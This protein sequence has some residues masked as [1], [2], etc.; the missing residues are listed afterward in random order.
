[1]ATLKERFL[2]LVGMSAAAAPAATPAP[3]KGA[4]AAGAGGGQLPPPITP[5]V[6]KG[7]Q[8]LPSFL[9]TATPQ[10]ILPQSDLALATTDILSLRTGTT[11][12]DMQALVAAS[13]DL[14]AAVFAYLRTAL[15][16]YVAVAKNRDGTFNVPATQLLQQ[17]IT[18]MDVLPDYKIGF[19]GVSSMNSLSESLAKEILTYGACGLELVLDKAR[20]PQQL[21]PVSVTTVKFG[22]DGTRRLPQQRLGGVVVDLDI[23]SFFYTSLD[24]DLLNPYAASPLQ[25]ALQPVIFAAD[26][27]N[28]LRRVV[29]KAVHPRLEVVIDSDKVSKL[30][31][32]DTWLDD[33]KRRV[34]MNAFVADVQ[35]KINGL[36]P[37]DALVY[38]DS[39]DIG[40]ITAGNVSVSDEWKVLQTIADAK[41]ATGAKTMPSILGH[42]SGSQN[43]ASVETMLFMKSATGA[44][45][46]KLNEIYS[47]AFT[48]AL[49]LFG[50]DVVCEWK[51]DSVDLRPDTELEAFK[52]MKQSRILEQLSYGFIT[53]EEAS[54]ALIG[55]LPGPSLKPLSGTLFFNPAPNASAEG[56]AG[57]GSQAAARSTRAS[58]RKRHSRPRGR[59]SSRSIKQ[60][61]ENGHHRKIRAPQARA[62]TGSRH[63]AIQSVRR[64]HRAA[65]LSGHAA[66]C[67][68]RQLLLRDERRPRGR[69]ADARRGGCDDRHAHDVLGDVAFPPHQEQQ[70][71]A[72][73]R[74]RRARRPGLHPHHVHGARHGR[75]VGALRVDDGHREPVALH[76][77]WLGAALHERQPGRFDRQQCAVPRGGHRRHHAHEPGAAAGGQHA[78]QEYDPRGGRQLAHRVRNGRLAEHH[79]GFGRHGEPSGRHHRAA[80]VVCR[81]PHH[82]RPVR[83]L[84]LRDRSR[85]RRAMTEITFEFYWL[86]ELWGPVN[87]LGLYAKSVEDPLSP[88]TT[89]DA[90]E[91]QRFT[92]DEAEAAAAKALAKSG[93]WK[94]TE[95]GFMVQL[96]EKDLV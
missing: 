40:Y 33:E 42:G 90:F 70:P 38:F 48:L 32:G 86:L 15:T 87:S 37:E 51:F 6:K 13:P 34:A 9:R 64:A 3:T 44:V 20:L 18:R 76:V 22:T 49:R 91:A 79:P 75:H 56:A 72:G 43:I 2:S 83:G 36:K 31:A 35:T 12:T 11:T 39:M 26:F 74:S 46:A 25:A 67:R 21:A 29:K 95:H 14:S 58:N 30:F 19:N 47:R 73:F 60:G 93:V 1:M 63:G 68:G 81:P 65:G 80:A 61:Q 5:N 84:V 53:D 28:D 41:V 66:A 52:V 78:P 92:K 45:Q 62:V 94:A 96:E 8:T 10:A 57:T 16:D 55:A 89:K 27:M 17:I 82:R 71:C 77:G 54:L 24:Q 7:E 88:A 59:R 23:P 69:R 85:V 50:Q 4:P